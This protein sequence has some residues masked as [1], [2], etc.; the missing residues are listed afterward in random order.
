MAG[1]NSSARGFLRG[2]F[3]GEKKTFRFKDKT[4]AVASAGGIQKGLL[5]LTRGGAAKLTLAGKQV[6]MQTPAPGSVRVT[7]SI[8]PS[9]PADEPGRCLSVAGSFRPKGK[10][11]ALKFP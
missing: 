7:I 3:V 4:G 10:K 5:R 1:R 8:Q 9:T 6:D 2:G 11:G